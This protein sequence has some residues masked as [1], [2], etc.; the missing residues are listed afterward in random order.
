MGDFQFEITR[1]E[2]S[3]ERPHGLRYSLTLHGPRR[4]APS[5]RWNG[6]SPGTARADGLGVGRCRNGPAPGLTSGG[7]S[8]PKW[9]VRLRGTEKWH[10]AVCYGI[11]GPDLIKFRYTTRS[12][13]F[14]SQRSVAEAL[15]KCSLP[16]GI[17]ATSKSPKYPAPGRSG[18]RVP[19]GSFEWPYATF[20]FRSAAQA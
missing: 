13:R 5:M 6:F 7:R 19:H 14:M 1:V 17:F 10:K 11:R 3:K 18:A 12:S 15:T 16:H 9:P 20:L 4:N 8:L 2:L